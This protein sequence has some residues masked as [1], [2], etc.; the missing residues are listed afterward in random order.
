MTGGTQVRYRV[1]V[2]HVT[3]LSR[4]VYDSKERQSSETSLTIPSGYLFDDW[5]YRVKV[6]VWGLPEPRSDPR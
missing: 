4:P 3:D 5:T 2:Y 1:L 6:R